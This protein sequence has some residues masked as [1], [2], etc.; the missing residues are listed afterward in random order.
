VL[1]NSLLSVPHN[2]FDCLL[3]DKARKST[4]ELVNRAQEYMRANLGES[5]TISDLLRLCNCSRG[6]LFTAFRKAKGYTP[7][8]FLAEQRLHAARRQLLDPGESTTVSSVALDCGFVHL[9]RFAAT[10]RER[11]GERPSE[12]LKTARL[13]F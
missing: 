1:L 10:Y 8:E 7:I 9:G 6:T 12:T 4:P 5:I 11:F 2:Q 3:D 13:R